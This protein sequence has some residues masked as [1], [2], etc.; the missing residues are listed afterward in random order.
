[1]LRNDDKARQPDPSPYEVIT[2]LKLTTQTGQQRTRP[3]INQARSYRAI[4]K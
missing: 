1:M 3:D 4:Q 2:M